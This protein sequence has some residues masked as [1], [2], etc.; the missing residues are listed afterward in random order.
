MDCAW[1]WDVRFVD[2]PM[3]MREPHELLPNSGNVTFKYAPLGRRG[4]D[5][6]FR[7]RCLRVRRIQDV[8]YFGEQVVDVLTAHQQAPQVV[9]VEAV[10][11][12]LVHIAANAV[13]AVDVGHVTTI[14]GQCA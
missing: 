14:T 11:R 8:F 6:I 5:K 4:V 7:K 13:L 9:L 1:C 10:P 3:V 2:K 12:V